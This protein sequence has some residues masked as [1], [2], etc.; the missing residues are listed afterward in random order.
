MTLAPM[1]AEQENVVSFLNRSNEHVFITGKA[2]TGKSHVL[3]WFQETTHKK[4]LVC[5]PTGVAA[6][7]VDGVTIHNLLGLGTGIPADEHIDIA[8]VRRKKS[9]LLEADALVVDEVSMVS[10]ELLDA[11]DRTL[12]SV[13]NNHEPFGGVQMIFFGDLYQLP[14]VKTT[15]FEQFLNYFDYKSA[16]FFDAHVWEE[17]EMHTFGLNHVHRQ[18]DAAF[19]DLLNGVRD[20]TLTPKQLD[21][22]NALGASPRTKESLL[23]A[24]RRKAVDDFNQANLR[25]LRGPVTELKARV[26]RE[27]DGQD[28]AE[29]SIKLKPGAKILMLSNDREDR[30]VNG[31]EAVVNSITMDTLWITTEDGKDHEIGRYQWVPAGTSPERFKDAPKFIQFPVK[32]A[33]GVTI[34]KSQGMTKKDIEIDL[35][36]GAFEG[37]QTYVAL[38]RVTSPGGLHLKRPVRMHDII[39]DPNVRRFFESL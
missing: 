31:T 27:W 39:V 35:G 25:K 15:E 32:L 13:R 28:P 16:W 1:T 17:T 21:D 18:S 23:L 19:K 36:T 20:G 3:R 12:R 7:N 5:A 22:L 2:G 8:T 26:N 9:I 11:M 34:H 37:G 10:S 6:I 29:R 24:S 4:V 30:W 33:W 14:P 38:S